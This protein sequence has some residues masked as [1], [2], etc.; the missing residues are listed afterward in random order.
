[1]LTRACRKTAPASGY[2]MPM[3]MMYTIPDWHRCNPFLLLSVPLRIQSESLI[4]LLVLMFHVTTS[5]CLG[6]IPQ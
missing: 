6:Y 4:M 2:V 5:D 1:M 3:M